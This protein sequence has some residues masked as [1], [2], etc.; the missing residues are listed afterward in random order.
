[1]AQKKRSAER[2]IEMERYDSKQVK[3]RSVKTGCR[4]WSTDFSTITFWIGRDKKKLIK[5]ALPK[6][7]CPVFSILLALWRLISMSQ[8]VKMRGSQRATARGDTTSKH[9]DIVMLCDWDSEGEQMQNRRGRLRKQEYSSSNYQPLT[10]FLCH[11][12]HVEG[13]SVKS[14]LHTDILN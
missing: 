10:S 11:S 9:T 12:P 5:E 3:E 14:Q 8:L 4:R 13:Q 6:K 7:R 1:M 2:V